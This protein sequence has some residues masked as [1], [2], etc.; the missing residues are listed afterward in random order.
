MEQ[1]E[2]ELAA[3]FNNCPARHLANRRLVLT[4]LVPVRLILHQNRPSPQR[5]AAIPTEALLT[6]SVHPSAPCP[7]LRWLTAAGG[8]VQVQAEGAGEARGGL[9]DWQRRHV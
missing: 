6:K 9:Q 1:A 7:P 2:K 8:R 4:Y 5:R 3:C